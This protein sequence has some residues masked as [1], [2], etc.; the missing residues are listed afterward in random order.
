MTVDNASVNLQNFA[1]DVRDGLSAPRKS[2]PCVYFYDTRGSQLY[3]D[4]CR[5]SEYYPARAEIEILQT[6]SA[7]IAGL[8]TED[9]VLIEL[10]SGSAIKTRYLIEAFLERHGSV[11]YIPIDVSETMLEASAAEL[12]SHYSQLT[13]EPVVARYE[14]ALARIEETHQ[15]PKLVLWLGGSIGN[16][17][18]KEAAAFLKNIIHGLTRQNYLLVGIDLFKDKSLLES[19]YNDSAGVTAEFNLNLLNRINHELGGSFDLGNF[20]H[21]AVFNEAA[22]RI[23]MYL[24]SN[25]EQT[26]QIRNLNLEIKLAAG[27]L[28]HTENSYKYKLEEIEF[29]A[30]RIGRRLR[31]QWF[32]SERRFSLNLFTA[33]N[34]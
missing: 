20:S 3:E 10:G 4:I 27:E 23:E 30:L 15:E 18:Q 29:L 7:E 12:R 8:F 2:I 17:G 1:D 9:A 16:L 11:H 21:H 24:Q 22:G 32:D 26:V 14:E 5:Q 19:A 33:D 25:I 6:N 13:V 34:S 28:I 31:K